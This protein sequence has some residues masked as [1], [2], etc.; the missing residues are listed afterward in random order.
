MIDLKAIR[1]RAE[2]YKNLEPSGIK[3][4]T[5][6]TPQTVIALLV[7]ITKLEAVVKAARP[8][9]NMGMDTDDEPCGEILDLS[10]AL[11]VLDGRAVTGGTD[12]E[13]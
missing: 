1:E 11:A 7:Y 13:P 12:N 8:I 4:I 2:K 6:C 10:Y 3:F 5:D 9:E